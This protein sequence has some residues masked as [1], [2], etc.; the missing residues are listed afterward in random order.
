MKYFLFLFYLAFSLA[1]YAQAYDSKGTLLWEINSPKGRSY[2][3][4]T[5]H[6]NDKSV[7]DFP[8]SVYEVF[9]RCNALA[10]EVNVFDLFI[11][12]DPIPNRAMPLLDRKGKLYT[13]S[14]KPTET[15]YGNEDGMPQFMDAWFQEKAELLKM[16]VMALESIEQ[17]TKAVEE[18]PFVE[19]QNRFRLG[20][21]EE[22]VLQSLYL[23]GRIDLIDRLIKGGLVGNK[24]AYKKLIEQRNASM[25]VNIARY[26]LADSVFFAVGAGH[27]Y[28][29][30]GI[31][32]LLREKGFKLRPV[33][34][35]TSEKPCKA[36]LTLKSMRSFEF[37]EQIDASWLKF[38]M[39]GMARKTSNP[40]TN[41]IVFTYKELGQGNTYEIKYIARDSSLSLLEYS[42]IYIA[43]PPQ[44]PYIMGYLDDGTEFTQGLSDVYPEGLVW[45]RLLINETHAV[46]ARCYGGNKFM[47]SDRPNKFFNNIVLE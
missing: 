9:L 18:I 10:V 43:S 32:S 30:K 21:S 15:Y 16:P 35:T 31:L 36:A 33:Q 29:D 6:T 3:F 4:G 17:Q 40:S 38:S 45:T 25:A 5:L 11:D 46:V 1:H 27:L 34:L 22:Q 26:C 44:S 28:G 12:K 14:G 37:V 19:Q 8:D 41:E 23:E 39:P 7:F 24:D 13:A 2:L 47:N 42:E 20:L